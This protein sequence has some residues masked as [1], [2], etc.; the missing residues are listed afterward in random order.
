MCYYFNI[1][2]S[3]QDGAVQKVDLTGTITK[4]KYLCHKIITRKGMQIKFGLKKLS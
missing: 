3:T 1:K 2:I 4:R